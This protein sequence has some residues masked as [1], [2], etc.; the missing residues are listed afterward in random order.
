MVGIVDR[1]HP[2]DRVVGPG[3]RSMSGVL[4]KLGNRSGETR[5]SSRPS[6]SLR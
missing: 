3:A 2:A 6:L 5:S 1:H 4:I